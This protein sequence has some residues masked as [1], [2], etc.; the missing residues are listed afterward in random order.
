MVTVTA[1]GTLFLI[2]AP[3]GDGDV[4]TVIPRGTLDIL[5]GLRFFAVEELKTARRYLRKAGITAPM[6]KLTLFELNEHTSKADLPALLQPLLEG[7]DMGLISEAGVPAVA[8][9]G[10]DLAALAHSRHI[11]VV[12]LTGPSSLLLA[13]MASGL[14]GQSFAFNGYLPVKPMERQKRLRQL[15]KHSITERQTQLFMETPYRNQSLLKDLLA[16]CSPRTRLC[17]AVSISTPEEFIKTLTVAEWK[18]TEID[19]HKNPC[20]F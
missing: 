5:R 1:K 20:I 12:P 18:K 16:V 9:P 8:D 17:L 13:L 2:P 15:E 4:E 10:A 3:I 11:K 19:I 14:N 7:S 6:E